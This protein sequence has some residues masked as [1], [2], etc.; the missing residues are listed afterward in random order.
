MDSQKHK[1]E[2]ITR[3]NSRVGRD[4]NRSIILNSVRQHQPVSRT[5]LSDITRLN[6]STVSSIVSTLLDENLLEESPDRGQ[7]IGRNP[8]NLSI[9]QGQHYV[10]AIFFDAPCTRVAIV[11][12][13]GTIKA[14]DEIWTNATTPEALVSQAIDR[15]NVLRSRLG[16]HRFRGIGASVAGIVDSTQM[17]VLYSVNLH[18]EHVNLG[19]IIHE[20][21]PGLEMVSVENDAKASALAELL[22]G[23]H[24]F[25]SANLVFLS[26]GLGIG[27]G[28][29][30]HGRILS[31]STHAAGEIGHMTIV[32]GG[33]P[34][35]CGSTGCWE[36]YASERAPVRAFIDMKKSAVDQQTPP[37]LSDLF[38]AARTGDEDS[39]TVL[40]QWA[41][42]IG[43][44]IGNMISLFDPDVV[45][46][47]GQI[48]H[49]WDI[50]SQDIS[51]AAHGPGVF[52]RQRK[53]TILPTSLSDN[54][55]LLGA[56]ALSIRRIFKDFS[57]SL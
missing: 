24:R 8:L 45:I 56:A 46:V 16:A 9:K 44:G 53:A 10:G 42:H 36:L 12:I 28:V 51:D 31:G 6:K 48:T 20:K 7:S 37:S 52:A 47:G 15:L 18:W 49:V 54:P 40:R 22:L 39:R 32:D 23:S 26:L 29:V 4:I 11:D 38:Q 19:N 1:H 25:S 43:V 57:I 33:E 41:Q 34:C 3:I 5:R 30:V 14:R 35:H 13:D 2:R 55:P 50:V 27:A 21:I 17:Q